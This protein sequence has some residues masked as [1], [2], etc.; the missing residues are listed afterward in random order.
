MANYGIRHPEN[1]DE[2]DEDEDEDEDS[3]E[4]RIPPPVPQI[5]E[6]FQKNGGR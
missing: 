1:L 6:R 4:P 5:P 3:D 2:M